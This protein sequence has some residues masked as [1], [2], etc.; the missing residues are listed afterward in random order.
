M[1]PIDPRIVKAKRFP[2][3]AAGMC[4]VFHFLVKSLKIVMKE[5]FKY[6]PMVEFHCKI[7]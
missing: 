5:F 3:H 1:P 6:L 7:G 4:S 2:A